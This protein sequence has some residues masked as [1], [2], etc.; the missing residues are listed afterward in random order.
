MRVYFS[1]QNIVLRKMFQTEEKEVTGGREKLHNE[2][3]KI[4]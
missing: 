2:D 3:I 1:F 4:L